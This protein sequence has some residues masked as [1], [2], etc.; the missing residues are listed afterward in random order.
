MTLKTKT[1]KT[2]LWGASPPFPLFHSS[3]CFLMSPGLTSPSPTPSSLLINP[4]STINLSVKISLFLPVVSSTASVFAKTLQKLPLSCRVSQRL[5]KLSWSLI[6]Q[7]ERKKE[8]GFGVCVLCCGG[9]VHSSEQAQSDL[10]G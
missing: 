4:P 1:T 5:I 7:S 9:H 3:H 8:G 6:S 10:T 2:T